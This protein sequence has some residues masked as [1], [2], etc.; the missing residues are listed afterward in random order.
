[1]G[2]NSRNGRT[3]Q[4]KK[5]TALFILLFLILFVAL[6]PLSVEEAMHDFEVG[7]KAGKR[8]KAG[9]TLYRVED[10]HYMY[11]YLPAAAILQ[12]PFSLPPL[13]AAKFSFYV[14]I[15]F[16]TFSILCLSYRLLP[17]ERGKSIYLPVLTFIILGKF[18]IREISLGQINVIITLLLLM[19][20]RRLPS[21]ETEGALK[22]D[23]CAGILWAVAIILKPYALI[24]LPYFIVK[25]AWRP[26]LSGLGFFLLS[27]FAPILF[28]GFRG[29]IAVHQD[30]ASTL[31]QSTQ[32][33]LAVE[34]NTSIIGFFMKWTGDRDI[35]FFLAG[36]T[37]AGLALLVLIIILKG[38]GMAQSPVLEGAVLL[39][40]IP[41]V[42]PLGWDYTFLMSALGI[43]LVL[44]NFSRYSTFWK[45]VLVLNCGMIT[46]SI[47]DIMGKT[48]F[49]I[50]M[51]WS[52]TT[53]NFLILTGYLAYLRF[54]KV[55]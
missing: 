22:K 41:L 34:Y 16:C 53:V 26:L 42:S 8:L 9:E 48:L 17:P 55:C 33:L 7:F 35:S 4:K 25:K 10:G 52:V 6:F 3:V 36:T 14:F 18:F 19:M 43:M 50:F 12:F 40:L 23:V 31:S 1:M 5:K 24:F 39:M 54:K 27:F 49:L 15:T 46:F 45:I 11:K 28:Y 47:W 21:G 51:F 20:I 32:G 30:W 37:V 38:R 13:S 29:N 44:Q 2:E